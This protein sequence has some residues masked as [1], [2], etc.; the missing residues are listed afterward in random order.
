MLR[1][2]R[3]RGSL[4]LSL[5]LVVALTIT[6]CRSAHPTK[7]P[8]GQTPADATSAV[9]EHEQSWRKMAPSSY[10]FT[11]VYGSMIG[12]RYARI[13]VVDSK[14]VSASPVEG[15]QRLL[16][17]TDKAVTVDGVFDRVRRDQK[18]ADEVKVTYDDT[19]GFPANVSVD[20]IKRAIDD[21][22]GY[23]VQQ[24]I[25][26]SGDLPTPK[27]TLD[28]ALATCR[29]PHVPKGAIRRVF[30]MKVGGTGQGD[31]RITDSRGRDLIDPLK[32]SPGEIEPRLRPAMGTT[33]IPSVGRV[34]LS[35]GRTVF[36]DSSYRLSP[37]TGRC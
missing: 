36:I 22:Y 11:L 20:A 31:L 10:E 37:N 16:Q 34:R 5:G 21:E 17:N 29:S 26:L 28:T 35:A 6:G 30:F 3:M 13:R 9:M 8:R 15:E 32:V 7:V 23:G 19:W 18:R 27:L 2:T 25:A 1:L 33:A 24:F 14:V 12:V 4:V